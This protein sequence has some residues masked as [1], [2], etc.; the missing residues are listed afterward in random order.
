MLAVAPSPS[1]VTS[2][3]VGGDTTVSWKHVRVSEIHID[4]YNSGNVLVAQTSAFPKR[5]KYSEPTP[6]AVD[7]GGRVEVQLQFANGGGAR[8]SP[9]S[10][11]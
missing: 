1:F 8:L 5:P 10:C 2:C 9:Q 11:M 7:A 3:G 4:Y 6:S